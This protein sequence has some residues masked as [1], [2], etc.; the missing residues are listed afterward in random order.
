[1][2]NFHLSSAILFNKVY[3]TVLY[4]INKDCRVVCL[5][6]FYNFLQDSGIDH[7]SLT[8]SEKSRQTA[9]RRYSKYLNSFRPTADG[10]GDLDSLM[11]GAIKKKLKIPENVQLVSSLNEITS[12]FV[13]G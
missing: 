3:F 11:N 1:M 10:D 2:V 7:M 8:A 13:F 4:I 12:I 6:D 9:M 5:Q